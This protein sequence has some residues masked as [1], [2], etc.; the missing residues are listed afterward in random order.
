VEAA[1]CTRSVKVK[2]TGSGI[3]K[4]LILALGALF[5]SVLTVQFTFMQ[6]GLAA[7]VL[8]GATCAVLGVYVVLRSMWRS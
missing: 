6:T 8:V 5:V 7:T 4:V 3:C 2:R 1:G